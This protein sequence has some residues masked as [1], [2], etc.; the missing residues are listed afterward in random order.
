MAEK[1]EMLVA[2]NGCKAYFEEKTDYQ[3]ECLW[4]DG[5]WPLAEFGELVEFV[6]EHRKTLKQAEMQTED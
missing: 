1:K 3:K 2:S 5:R 6:R 4:I